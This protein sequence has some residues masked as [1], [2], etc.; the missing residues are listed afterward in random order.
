[1][2]PINLATTAGF[3]LHSL[4]AVLL[5]FPGNIRLWKGLPGTNALAYLAHSEFRK[6]KVFKI[7]P[8]SSSMFENIFD[9]T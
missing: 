8:T 9:V 7:G 6:K 2:M 4:N 5:A 1:M 3:N